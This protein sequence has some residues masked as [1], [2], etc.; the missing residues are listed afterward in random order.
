MYVTL[1]ECQECCLRFLVLHCIHNLLTNISRTY[2]QSGSYSYLLVVCGKSLV[3]ISTKNPAIIRSYRGFP[4]PFQ[5]N[6]SI[7]FLCKP[8]SLPATRFPTHYPLT[9][10]TLMPFSVKYPQPYSNHSQHQLHGPENLRRCHLYRQII[11]HLL[12]QLA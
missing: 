3:Q 7:A 10:L 4:Q 2:Q 8:R 5:A 11:P 9:A 12:K 1:G 6:A